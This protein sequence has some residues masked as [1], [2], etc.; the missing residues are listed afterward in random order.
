VLQIAELVK[1]PVESPFFLPLQALEVFGCSGCFPAPVSMQ[2]EPLI[3]ARTCSVH[4]F[5]LARQR[6]WGGEVIPG[7]FAKS[8]VEVA[9][10]DCGNQVEKKIA[11]LL[12]E[13]PQERNHSLNLERELQVGST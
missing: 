4:P 6:G 1:E 10:W 3:P 11:L 9:S 12:D 2:S 7:C 13:M 8:V 5:Q